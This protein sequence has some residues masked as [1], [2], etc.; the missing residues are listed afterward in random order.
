MRLDTLRRPALHDPPATTLPRNDAEDLARVARIR[1]GDRV[2][3]EQMYRAYYRPLVGFVYTYLRSDSLA[4]E[5]VQELFLAIWRHRS[6]WELQT[7]LR[8]Y[9]FKSARNRALNH[10]RHAG[11]ASAAHADAASE[12]RTIAMGEI[13]PAIDEQVEAGEL[14]AAAQRTIDRLP[15][16]C[17][18]AFTLCRAHGLSYAETA[19]V[20]GISEQT[21]KVQMGRALMAL[22]AG[23]ARW[24]P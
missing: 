20:M 24:L 12:S 22:R 16:R 6:R 5:E 14:A 4:E 15:P 1:T 11:V 7:T 18:M 3:F 10:L 2:A 23:L 13:Q 19:Q 9:L 17:R 8:S 21:V